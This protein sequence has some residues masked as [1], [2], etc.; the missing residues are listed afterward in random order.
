MHREVISPLFSPFFL[1]AM[2]E[3]KKVFLEVVNNIESIFRAE[4]HYIW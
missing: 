3:P 2:F 4:T 1:S